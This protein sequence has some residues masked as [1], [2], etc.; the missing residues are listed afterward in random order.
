VAQVSLSPD[1]EKLKRCARCEMQKPLV[2]FRN[3][4]ARPD[5]IRPYCRDCRKATC[6]EWY[7]RNIETERERARNRKRVNGPKDRERNKKWA[8]ANPEQARYHS[9]KKLLGSKYNMTIEEHDA[10]F[11]SQ[12]SVCGACGSAEPN[13]KKGWSTDH[14]HSTGVV[15]GIVCHHCNIGIGHAKDSIKTLRAWISYLEKAVSPSG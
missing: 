1:S 5:S 12:G 8:A 11:A 13:S 9:R 14:C 10:L 7:L 4:K 2:D 15:R 3:N 6:R